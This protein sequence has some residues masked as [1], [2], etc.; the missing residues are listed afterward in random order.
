MASRD[1]VSVS[2]SCQ[3]NQIR[4]SGEAEDPPSK[5]FNGNKT[6]LDA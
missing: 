1:F 4:R 3:E 5:G 6:A 2:V